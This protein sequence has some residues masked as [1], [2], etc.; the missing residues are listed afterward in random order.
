MMHHTTLWLKLKVQKCFW[1]QCWK[2]PVIHKDQDRDQSGMST[3]WPVPWFDYTYALDA[4]E[5]LEFLKRTFINSIPIR[6]I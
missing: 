4:L 2:C 3:Y 6:L 5:D 1:L